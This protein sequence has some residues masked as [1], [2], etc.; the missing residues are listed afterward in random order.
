MIQGIAEFD[1]FFNVTEYIY[2]CEQVYDQQLCF[3]CEAIIASG[4]KIITLCGPT[5][6][7]KT[8]TA[9]K[10]FAYLTEMGKT[11]HVIS[12]DDF[13]FDRDVIAQKCE[14]RGVALEYES[15]FTLDLSLLSCVLKDI[16]LGKDVLVPIYN[17]SS[18]KRNGYVEHH[19]TGE[20]IFIFEGIQ[21]LY[22]EV[23]VLYN[24]VHHFN[25]YISVEDGISFGDFSFDK[26]TVRFLRR[27][28]R[29]FK[30]RA[31]SVDF[32]CSI[33]K[34]VREN[35][36]KNIFPNIEKA[37]I[38]INS[39]LGYEINVLKYDAESILKTVS[40][41]SP[42]YYIIKQMSEMLSR[43]SLIAEESVPSD[44]VLREFID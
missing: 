37:D 38:K 16:S 14:E 7:G 8:T 43:I 31:A 30:H 26:E 18:G 36:E 9:N 6:S 28:V 17:F 24:H 21:A 1:E 11:V 3:T 44:S 20:D 41:S 19:L 12:F 23:S 40:V 42:Y 34:T 25:V 39:T 29:D 5:C 15:A 35:E 2:R 13:Y 27:I 4:A 32:T 22:D 10:L 33:W